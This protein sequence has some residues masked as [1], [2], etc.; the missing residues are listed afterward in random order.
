MKKKSVVAVI[1]FGLMVITVICI[2]IKK[3]SFIDQT[4]ASRW[5]E[6]RM[7]QMSLFY[8]ATDTEGLDSF[9][10]ADLSHQ[11]QSAL[12][13]SAFASS[14]VT[15]EAGI[16]FPYAVSVS[17]KVTI[18]Y[19]GKT[20]ETAALGVEQRFFTF[21]PVDLIYGAYISANELMDDGI[22]ID[23]VTAWN[24]F[25]SSDVVGKS[26]TIGGVPHYIKGVTAKKDDRISKAAGLDKALCYISLDSMKKFGNAEGSFCYEVVLPDPVDDFAT[27]LMGET[28]GDKA[29]DIIVVDNTHRFNMSQCLSKITQTGIRSMSTKGIIFPYFENEARAWEDILARWYGFLVVLTFIWLTTLFMIY[30]DF[31][32]TAGYKKLKKSLKPVAPWKWKIWRIIG[33]LRRSKH[34]KETMD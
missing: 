16:S 2:N 31:R 34:E 22:V 32:R 12:D 25:G 8:P 20:V 19:E 10:F 15:D 1:L 6:D 3:N 5:S 14:G 29:K 24:L 28:I 30:I 17:G 13:K 33:D 26:V 7:E 11:L 21:H 4:A 27:N 9:H 18:E 23:D